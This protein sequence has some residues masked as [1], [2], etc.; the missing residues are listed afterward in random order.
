MNSMTIK[1]NQNNAF[2]KEISKLEYQVFQTIK[3]TFFFLTPL[4]SLLK[5]A[6]RFYVESNINAFRNNHLS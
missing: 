6:V 3:W 5:N 1:L 4:I 2:S